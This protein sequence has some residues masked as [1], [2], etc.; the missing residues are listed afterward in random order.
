MVHFVLPAGTAPR[1]QQ[2]DL[3][4]ALAGHQRH[5]FV[6]G[7]VID[8]LDKPLVER[9]L[10]ALT[11]GLSVC[12]SLEL[13]IVGEGEN[14]KQLQ[15]LIRKLGLASH[16][17]LPGEGAA[18][19]WLEHVDVYVLPQT[20]PGLSEIADAI[21]AMRY[22]VP[23]LGPAGASLGDIITAKTGA[24]IEISD[25][26]ILARQFIRLQQDETLRKQLGVEAR[27][28][29]ETLTFERLLADMSNVLTFS[30]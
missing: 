4:R 20:D 7:S 16:V 30:L 21:L 9:L 12:S 1:E 6:I 17:W 2:S 3:F 8:G 23:V 13:V 22:G 24:L 18:A 14:R 15:W 5:R 11:V 27:L 28:H 10:G 25:A 26:E 29:A 19:R